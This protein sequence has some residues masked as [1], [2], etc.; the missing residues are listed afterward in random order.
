MNAG[1]A[2]FRGGVL[3][4]VVVLAGCSSTTLFRSNFT[5]TPIGQAPTTADIGTVKT[6]GAVIV[7]A[8]PVLPSGKWVQMSRPNAD[9][10]NAS[11][12]GNLKE[13]KGDGHYT[14]AATVFMPSSTT[15]KATIQFERQNEDL[16]GITNFLHLD[17]LPTNQ[18]RIDDLSS[19]DFG[20][21]TRDKPFIVQV[22]LDIGPTPTAHIVLAGDGAS[23]TKD[24]AILPPFIPMSHQFGA[25]RL[26]MQFPNTG[27]LQATNISVTRRND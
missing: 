25:V 24:H 8:A 12:Q 6:A 16:S 27:T 9:T 22:T 18:V 23:G 13:V 5:P 20:S 11:F 10:S 19:T 2:F 14:F 1:K 26:A 4:A 17:L 7:I 21:F 3:L 15:G